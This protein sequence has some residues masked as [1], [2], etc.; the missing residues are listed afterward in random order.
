MIYNTP[1]VLQNRILLLLLKGVHNMDIKLNAILSEDAKSKITEVNQQVF[2]G[3]KFVK[4]EIELYIGRT[5]VTV[6]Q[7]VVHSELPMDGPISEETSE[8]IVGVRLDVRIDTNVVSVIRAKGKYTLQ[9]DDKTTGTVEADQGAHIKI[10]CYGP[11]REKVLELY[12]LIRGGKIRPSDE[13][14]QQQIAGGPDL[15]EETRGLLRASNAD[16]ASLK[17]ELQNLQRTLDSSL[18]NEKILLEELK[19]TRQGLSF[20]GEMVDRQRDELQK[21][22]KKLAKIAG[23]CRKLGESRWRVTLCSTVANAIA[24]ILTDDM[25]S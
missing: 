5:R 18:N 2:H 20:A 12:E 23:L 17:K 22:R 24:G 25:G 19:E 9:D 6:R 8:L 16:K 15:L 14:D 11:T 4:T 7:G 10:S 13:Y 21:V 1:A 3:A